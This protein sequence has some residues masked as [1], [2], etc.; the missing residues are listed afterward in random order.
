[1]AHGRHRLAL[2]G[3]QR[4]HASQSSHRI[5]SPVVSADGTVQAAEVDKLS[6]RVVLSERKMFEDIAEFRRV[7]QFR[8]GSPLPC[9]VACVF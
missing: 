7:K 2:K 5:V 3:L 1:M 8:N 9:C 6:L 4:R